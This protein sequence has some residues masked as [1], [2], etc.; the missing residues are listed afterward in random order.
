MQGMNDKGLGMQYIH[1][2]ICSADVSVTGR[3]LA[4]EFE[5]TSR[6]AWDD[7]TKSGTTVSEA[8]LWKTSRASGVQ[9]PVSAALRQ[10]TEA[11]GG[12]L[13]GEELVGPS[14]LR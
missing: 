11:T 3:F 8:P 5:S 9:L 10:H 14:E 6:V 1:P 12:S 2:R 4:V 7:R 13:V